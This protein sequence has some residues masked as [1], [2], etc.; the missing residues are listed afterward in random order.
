VKPLPAP[1]AGRAG[2]PWNEAKATDQPVANASCPKITVVTPSYN[3]AQF[4]E[5][6]I[7]SVLLQRYPNL[8]YIVI[9]GGST[10]GSVEVLE[11]YSP[12][13]TWWVSERD[14]GQV[15]AINKGLRRAT[16]EWV[17]W[18]NSD[19]IYYQNALWQVART[20]QRHRDAVLILGNVNLIDGCDAVIT[21]LLFVR[22]T[23]RSVLAEGMVLTNQAAFWRRDL[24]DSIGWLDERFDHAF[25]FD[26]FLRT[27][28][29]GPAYHID[30]ILGAYR[31]HSDAKTSRF[32]QHSAE[33]R[34]RVLADRQLSWWQVQLYRMRRV[35]LL[36][37]NGHIAYLV[38]AVIRRLLGVR[39]DLVS[40]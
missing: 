33:E 7:R 39:K 36:I 38:R 12:W 23:Y 11:R 37:A 32:L 6:T 27:L 18:Q 14:Q 31:I 4:L 16:G 34:R 5:Q 10:D 25:D 19:D 13:L 26:W 28:K 15:D 17:A 29:A 22:P 40:Q 20:A 35:L 24:H 9:D 30:R 1:P 2:W 21:D 3:Q 8:E